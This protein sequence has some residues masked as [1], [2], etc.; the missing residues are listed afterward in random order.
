MFLL[1]FILADFGLYP[2]QHNHFIRVLLLRWWQRLFIIND[3]RTRFVLFTFFFL[4]RSN[5]NIDFCRQLLTA[6]TTCN[7]KTR[8]IK[9]KN[10]YVIVNDSQK[11]KFFFFRTI[12]RNKKAFCWFIKIAPIIC[13]HL[14]DEIF[15]SNS[16][17]K[18][19]NFNNNQYLFRIEGI[20]TLNLV[21][22]FAFMHVLHSN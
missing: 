17:L 22:V 12:L 1:K 15:K 5:L 19:S 4:L 7:Y 13:T 9:F 11:K 14:S 21:C 16:K 3:L 2:P 6:P 20:Q 18:K 10:H 8:H